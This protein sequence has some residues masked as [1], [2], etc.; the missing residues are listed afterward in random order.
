MQKCM[1]F[2]YIIYSAK[3]AKK[4]IGVTENI[5]TRV[6][7]HRIDQVPFTANAND[8][9]LIYYEVFISKKDAYAEERF[10]KTGKGRERLKF[11]LNET[12]IL[13]RKGAPNG[14]APLSKSG[15]P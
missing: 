14:K 10:L 3:L 15:T 5:A 12:M 4:Y 7:Q 8:W 9:N 2:I 13:V 11:L 1:Y 6:K